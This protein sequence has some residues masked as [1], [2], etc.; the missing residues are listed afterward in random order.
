MCVDL[1]SFAGA[2]FPHTVVMRYPVRCST[3]FARISS[4]I[5]F[6]TRTHLV[7]R[8]AYFASLQKGHCVFAALL[9]VII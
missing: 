8:E 2:P 5:P 1:V 4:D 3:L 6:D 7:V 9:V